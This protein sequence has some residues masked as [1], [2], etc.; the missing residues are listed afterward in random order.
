MW[1]FKVTASVI[2]SPTVTP[3]KCVYFALLMRG[4]FEAKQLLTG[5]GNY[6]QKCSWLNSLGFTVNPEPDNELARQLFVLAGYFHP[7][8]CTVSLSVSYHGRRSLF[9]HTDTS[10]VRVFVCVDTLVCI[11][12]PTPCL[13]MIEMWFVVNVPV[14][15]IFFVSTYKISYSKKRKKM[16]WLYLLADRGVHKKQ[17]Y[18]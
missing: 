7:N 11:H 2:Y 10:I 17:L 9:W 3:F 8:S 14:Y 4:H 18:L 13:Q 6:L 1:V 12:T 5:P 16:M 15:T